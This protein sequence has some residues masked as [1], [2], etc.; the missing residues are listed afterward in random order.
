MNMNFLE[1]LRGLDPRDPGRWPLTVLAGAVG[2]TFLLLTLL[3]VW[4][5]VWQSV[6]PEL[7]Q[8]ENEELSLRQEFQQKH[9]KAVNLSVY[10]QQLTDLQRCFGSCRAGPRCRTSSST[11]RRPPSRRACNRSSSS[12]SPR[13]RRTSTRS[14]PSK[15]CSLAAIT[16]SA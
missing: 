16:S 7:Q 5:F 12:P 6:R 1:E 14:C 2:T 15:W 8:R 4:F 3:L 9:A 11:S 13:S 10:K